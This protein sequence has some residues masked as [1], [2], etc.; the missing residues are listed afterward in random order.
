MEK[1][2]RLSE[3]RLDASEQS[4]PLF[5]SLSLS[6]P[7]PVRPQAQFLHGVFHRDQ[8]AHVK[9]DGVE[10]VLGGGV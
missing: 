1:G 2:G 4:A 7:L 9:G 10:T 5:L 3:A 8:V 6:L